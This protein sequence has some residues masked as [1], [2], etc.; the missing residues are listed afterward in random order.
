[1]T[2]TPLPPFAANEPAIAAQAAATTKPSPTP[3]T[4]F[5]AS[6][7]EGSG[8]LLSPPI[9]AI[10]VFVLVG[11]AL[12]LMRLG[13]PVLSPLLL[14]FFLV[15]LALPAFRFLKRKG[16]KKGLALL[17]LVVG[18]L[19]IGLTLAV[20]AYL[21]VQRL[22]SGLATHTGDIEQAVNGL[23]GN[24]SGSESLRQVAVN[25]F[26]A[27]AG[28]L[29]GV[30]T[31]FSISILLA[32]F[33]I[34]EAPRLGGLMRTSMKELPFLG[35][36]PQ[37]MDAAITYF[38][39]RLRLNVITGLAFG[40]FLWVIGVDYALLWGIIAIFL[41]FIPYIG[42]V[43][44][45][46]PPVLLALAEFGLGMALVVIVAVTLINFTVENLLAPSMTG[47]SLSLSPAVVFVSFLF[48]TWLLGPVG[49]LVAMP[50]TVLLMI[51]F[52]RYSMTRWVAEI[53]GTAPR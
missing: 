42:L 24:V 16:I 15:T 14:A 29:T 49:A 30:I 9:V 36:T 26:V 11:L 21:S 5:P 20:L 1:M 40:L 41:S 27:F 2:V 43:V 18:M 23:L 32:V 34:V 33:L 38:M 50:I 35:M 10:S 31:Q 53:I 22:V 7:A 51:T 3:A 44:A 17:L 47:R 25:F 52:Q 48:W 45:A 12:A 28:V 6:P 19:V 4:A 39:V 46:A 37:V 8:A 13:A